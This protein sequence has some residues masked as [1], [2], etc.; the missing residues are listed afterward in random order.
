[1]INI[2]NPDYFEDVANLRATEAW[3]KESSTEKEIAQHYQVFLEQSKREVSDLYAQY[4]EEGLVDYSV[5]NRRLTST[6]VAQYQNMIQENINQNRDLYDEEMMLELQ[7]L[8][9][10]RNLNIIESK[11]SL[12]EASLILAVSKSILTVTD[13]L[14]ETAEYTYNHSTY[15]MHR[16]AGAILSFEKLSQGKVSDL[17]Y[18]DWTGDNFVD[19]I[20]HSRHALKRDIKKSI[21]TGIR[22]NEPYQKVVKKLTDLT[23]GGKGYKAIHTVLRGETTRVIAESTMATYGQLGA[24]KYQFIATLDNRTTEICSRTDGRVFN[25]ED[26]EVG[27]NFPPLHFSCRSTCVPYFDEDDLSEVERIARDPNGNNYK[28]PA[29]ISYTEWNQKYN[30]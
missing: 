2:S 6:Q 28:I 15:D 18:S 16:K 9:D 14:S 11:T 26:K 27:V 23:S 25:L 17:I 1:M 30:K 29:N 21:V 22:R 4:G 12:I 24:K 20:K 13:S 3:R 19:A 7:K 10:K 5:L 8:K